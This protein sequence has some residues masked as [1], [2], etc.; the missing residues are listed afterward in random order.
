M[1]GL[2]PIF[3]L[4]SPHWQKMPKLPDF[5]KKYPINPDLIIKSAIYLDRMELHN[6]ANGIKSNNPKGGWYWS[7]S[8]LL[9]FF[10]SLAVDAIAFNAICSIPFLNRCSVPFKCSKAMSSAALKN[11]ITTRLA[12]AM[13][14]S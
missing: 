5:V 2:V 8:L 3:F 14:S 10:S 13:F 9:S 7:S 6:S 12:V 11:E 1:K 4:F